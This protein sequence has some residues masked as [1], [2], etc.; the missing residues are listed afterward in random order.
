[1]RCKIEGCAREANAMG[2]CFKHYMRQRR[3]GNPAV[4]SKPG[5]KP[6][7]PSTD[8]TGEN[9]ALRQENAALRQENAALHQE[10]IRVSEEIARWHRLAVE[11]RTRLYRILE[12][13]R[14]TLI[15]SA[16][17]RRKIVRCLHPDTE[18][19]PVKKKRLDEA[20]RIFNG[21]RIQVEPD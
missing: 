12:A 14:R 2:L 17:D 9:A 15:V 8:E 5:P 11:Y 6:V 7:D 16:T 13:P 19:D 3:T 21:L 4:R 10:I 1:M 20:F 18:T